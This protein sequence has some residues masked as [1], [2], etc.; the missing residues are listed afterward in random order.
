MPNVGLFW[1]IIHISVRR[2]FVSS[3]SVAIQ[4]SASCKKYKQW[5]N[6]RQGTGKAIKSFLLFHHFQD[7]RPHIACCKEKTVIS[8]SNL[9][10][11]IMY[12]VNLQ[13]GGSCP[14][15]LLRWLG[16]LHSKTLRCNQQSEKG[17]RMS[18]VYKWFPRRSVIYCPEN[19]WTYSVCGS[20]EGEV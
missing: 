6:I 18:G 4:G 17:S 3:V 1:G 16:K 10:P 8:R 20:D 2:W 13:L 19:S 12:V 9:G 5:F 15:L 11:Q 7:R 14:A